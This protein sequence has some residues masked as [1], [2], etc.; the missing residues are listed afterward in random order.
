MPGC[1][2]IQGSFG[3]LWN[4]N[5][6]EYKISGETHVVNEIPG[7]SDDNGGSKEN[8]A[9]MNKKPTKNISDILVPEKHFCS[10]PLFT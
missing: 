7:S 9:K 5:T 10:L 2:G 3:D 4:I 1:S 8:V 6:E